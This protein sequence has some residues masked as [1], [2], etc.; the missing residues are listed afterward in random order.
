[1]LLHLLDHL[2][3]V[4]VMRP[5][6]LKLFPALAGSLLLLVLHLVLFV[7]LVELLL[8]AGVEL[9]NIYLFVVVGLAVGLRLVQGDLESDFIFGFALVV[10]LLIALDE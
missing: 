2:E 5:L 8:Q 1:M 7:E 4:V 6:L 3:L 10:Y 9:R